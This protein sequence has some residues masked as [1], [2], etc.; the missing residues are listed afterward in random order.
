MAEEIK[1]SELPEA[2]AM[3]DGDVFPIVHNGETKKVD[4]A[5][6]KKFCTDYI[7]SEILGGES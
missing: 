5:A 2:S 4:I 3:E 7:D 6:V 1:I